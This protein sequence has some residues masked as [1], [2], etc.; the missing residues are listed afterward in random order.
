M[1][2][3]TK[4]RLELFS[5]RSNP[6]LAE[7]IGTGDVTTLATVPESAMARASDLTMRTLAGPEI[8]SARRHLCLLAGVTPG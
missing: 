4:K 7:D 6:A 5:G 1:E 8:D 2:L 3:V